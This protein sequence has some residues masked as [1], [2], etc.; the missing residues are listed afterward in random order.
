MLDRNHPKRLRFL[1]I[2]GLAALL[3][4]PAFADEPTEKEHHGLFGE[5]ED[6]PNVF[7]FKARSG[8]FLGIGLTSMSDAL[9][10]HFDVGGDSGV[11]VANVIEDT[12][13]DRAGLLVG[14]I[15]TTIDGHPARSP[16]DVRRIVR[17][18]EEGQIVDIQ[19]IRAGEA[20]DITAEIASRENSEIDVSNFL[21]NFDHLGEMG[22]SLGQ[23]D[24]E[25]I[26]QHGLKIGAESAREAM[27][28][29]RHLFENGDWEHMM[30]R[31]GNIDYEALEK[32]ME[33]LRERMH[34]LEERLENRQ[35]P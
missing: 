11:M 3:A 2:A 29:V 14:D 16:R 4:L 32:R 22:E 25:S 12:P 27:E 30:E 26:G 9:L 28:S 19:V 13:A 6:C 24:W 10:E 20:L 15:I 1:L 8:G 23:I 21:I 31:V 5:C 18:A 33:E 17:L 34:E 7:T 35:D